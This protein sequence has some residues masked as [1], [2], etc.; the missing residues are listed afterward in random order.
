MSEWNMFVAV[1][2]ASIELLIF[3]QEWMFSRICVVLVAVVEK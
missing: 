1:D 2:I 3:E